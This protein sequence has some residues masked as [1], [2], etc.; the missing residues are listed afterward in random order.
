MSRGPGAIERGVLDALAAYG[1]QMARTR[2]ERA[3]WLQRQPKKIQALL[4]TDDND[5]LDAISLAELIFRGKPSK[6]QLGSVRRAIR[7]LAARGTIVDVPGAA[8]IFATRSR[9][10][11][12]LA[13]RPPVGQKNFPTTPSP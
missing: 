4:A 2:A 10:M 1:R 11:W 8:P 9:T 12:R 3:V 7:R 5:A 6:A 13:D